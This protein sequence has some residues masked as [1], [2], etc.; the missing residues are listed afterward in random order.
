[1]LQEGDRSKLQANCFVFSKFRVIF[2]LLTL[3]IVP[4]SLLYLPLIILVLFTVTNML[5]LSF[6][7]GT[8]SNLSSVLLIVTWFWR[9][10]Y[11]WS[12]I[13]C[14]ELKHSFS[15]LPLLMTCDSMMLVV[16]LVDRMDVMSN[17]KSP[18]CWRCWCYW[19]MLVVGLWCC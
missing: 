1:M 15:L 5:S 19:R 18:C 10:S 6:S 8:K 11:Y 3:I 4:V 7:F 9:W 12:C 14:F 17:T 13:V 2:F 16:Q